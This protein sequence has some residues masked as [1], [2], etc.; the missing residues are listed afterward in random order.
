[1]RTDVRT[2]RVN[3]CE[4]S[5]LIERHLSNYKA[6]YTFIHYSTSTNRVLIL[7]ELLLGASEKPLSSWSLDFRRKRQRNASP[8][9]NK[10]YKVKNKTK[11]KTRMM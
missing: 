1:M 3:V 10:Y 8:D 7:C 4:S 2:K 5:F 11:Q 9:S 6:F